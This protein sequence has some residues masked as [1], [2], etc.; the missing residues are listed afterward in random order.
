MMT[1]Q[2][3]TRKEVERLV[4][5]HFQDAREELGRKAEY[6]GTFIQELRSAEFEAGKLILE[7]SDGPV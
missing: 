3:E 5:A 6:E 7:F 1:Y 2:T 4:H